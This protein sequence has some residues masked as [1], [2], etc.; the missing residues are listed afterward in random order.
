MNALGLIFSNL[1]E[2]AVPE[3]TNKRTMGSV[4]FGGRYRII[5]FVLSNM[6]NAG[7]NTV[8]IITKS[9]YQSLMDHVG[10]G[11]EWDLA[12]KNGG[13]HILPPFGAT[14]SNF[15]Y[16][17]KV[18]A[19]RSVSGFINNTRERYVVLS[20]CD[21]VANVDLSDVFRQHIETGA[22]VTMV[23]MKK[24]ITP[25]EA[26]TSTVFQVDFSG[27]ILRMIC[28][29]HDSG[30]QKVSMNLWVI[31]K[32]LL[33]GLI[34]EATTQGAHHMEKDIFAHRCKSLNI[35]GYLFEGYSAKID[36]LQNYFARNMDLLDSRVRRSLFGENR[37]FTKIKDAVPSHYTQD[38]LVEN[39]LIAD[40]CM[41]EGQVKNSVLFRGVKVEK[42]AKV[43]NCILMQDSTVC[44]HAEL[45][46][47]ILDK[48]V[49]IK[50]GRVLS[51]H[52]TY[53][54]YI[55]KGSIV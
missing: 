4:P 16:K 25:R 38:S 48:N 27:R 28:G 36:S 41:I 11:K 39:S 17:G 21:I 34:E 42:G 3:I 50:D 6:T 26:Q 45:H 2:D 13:L 20:D 31:E 55:S 43:E 32:T 52:E 35:R 44:E 15:V 12:R 37:I 23:Y 29:G 46:A 40:G 5:D 9:N 7:I 33:Q 51:G 18:Q 49:T 30:M 10:S 53:P 1:H 8:G 22:D 47:V 54:V 24:Q 19:L 14:E